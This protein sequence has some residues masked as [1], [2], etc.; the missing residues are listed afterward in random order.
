MVNNLI[1]S[2]VALIIITI[3]I[4]IFVIQNIKIEKYADLTDTNNIR[5]LIYLYKGVN[6]CPNCATFNNTW[7][8]VQ[9]LV[10]ENPFF[11]QYKTEQYNISNDLI[12]IKYAKDNNITN[13]PTII[14]VSPEGVNK[15]MGNNNAI[16]IL[17]WANSF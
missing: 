4:I 7:K 13:V 11:Y 15:Y 14:Y 5:K 17:S 3:I 6:E 2:L 12:G 9:V 8:T 16:D 1:I 10:I